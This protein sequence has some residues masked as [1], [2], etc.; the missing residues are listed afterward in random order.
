[1]LDELRRQDWA[2]RSVRRFDRQVVSARG[3]FRAIHGREATT[4]E[5]A[6]AL[7]VPVERVRDHRD[8]V[9]RA[10]VASLNSAVGTEDGEEAGERIDSLVAGDERS[11]PETATMLS[12][13]KAEL[14]AAIDALP[15]RDRQVLVLLYVESRRPRRAPRGATAR[16]SSSST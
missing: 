15:D 10:D 7:A 6:D 11:R 2:P 3:T 9:R 8:H 12:S 5:L 16:G 14:R 4:V 1:V 13:A